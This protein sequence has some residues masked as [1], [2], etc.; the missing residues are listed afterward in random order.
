MKYVYFYHYRYEG[1]IDEKIMI[2]NGSGIIDCDDKIDDYGIYKTVKEE[3][4]RDFLNGIKDE[5]IKTQI[6]VNCFCVTSLSFLHEV[7][8]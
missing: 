7:N 6:T 4:F 8:E 2:Y 5:I 1:I 3:I